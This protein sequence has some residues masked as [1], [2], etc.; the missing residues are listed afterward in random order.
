MS[1]NEDSGREGKSNFLSV[2]LGRRAAGAVH[3][4]FA[5][6]L[7]VQFGDWLL[8]IGCGGAQLSACGLHVTAARLRPLL[9]VVDRGDIVVCKDGVF[10]FYSGSG[11][12]TLGFGDVAE[13]DLR[14]PRIC[15]ERGRIADSGLYRQLAGVDFA[16]GI[17]LELDAAA[18][19]G[20]EQ[21]AAA[22]KS[23]YRRNSQLINFFI[24]RGRGL[25]PSGD[26]ILLGFTLV[27]LLFGEFADWRRALSG[28]IAGDKTTLV[29]AT[30]LRALLCGYCG[31]ALLQLARLLDGAD[32]AAIDSAIRA[33]R[34]YGHTSGTDSVFGFFIG[35]TFLAGPVAGAAAA[36]QPGWLINMER[37]MVYGN[38]G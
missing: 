21:L 24:G 7:N 1:G 27:L 20:L 9:A 13:V 14:L 35:L 15:C 34:A 6:G 30:A 26:D 23:D 5:N 28:A 37:G 32:S 33:A 12:L 2:C 18:Q 36:R 11:V 8:F 10:R 4:C 17:G 22:D 16:R 3:S 31:E 29:S 19:T 38:H 25:T